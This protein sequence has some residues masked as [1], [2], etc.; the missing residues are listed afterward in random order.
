MMEA[1]TA[2][3]SLLDRFSSIPLSAEPR[4]CPGVVLRGLEHLWIEVR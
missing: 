2:F 3:A 1:H 4:Y